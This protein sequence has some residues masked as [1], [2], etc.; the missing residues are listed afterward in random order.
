MSFIFAQFNI[1][2]RDRLYCTFGLAS[3]M[4]T[5]THTFN[6]IKDEDLYTVCTVLCLSPTN[7]DENC[8]IARVSPSG[9]LLRL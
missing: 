2:N 3:N 4:S 5:H 1:K 6:L 7:T 8:C 9:A